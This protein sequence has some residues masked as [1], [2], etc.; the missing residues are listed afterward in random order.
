MFS[1]PLNSFSKLSSPEKESFLQ[2]SLSAV[3]GGF[4]VFVYIFHIYISA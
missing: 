4:I 1:P 2:Q 3:Q